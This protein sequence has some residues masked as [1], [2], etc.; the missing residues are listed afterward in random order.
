MIFCKFELG[1]LAG[2]KDADFYLGVEIGV[3]FIFQVFFKFFF[4]VGK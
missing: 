4:Y 1:L 3:L 2:R